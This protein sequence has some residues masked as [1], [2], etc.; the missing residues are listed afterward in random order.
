M[1]CVKGVSYSE[2]RCT[3]FI[4]TIGSAPRSAT[5]NDETTASKFGKTLSTG[6]WGGCSNGVPPVAAAALARQSRRA[7]NGFRQTPRRRAYK[8]S[9]LRGMQL[10]ALNAFAA[11]KTV[12]VWGVEAYKF[13]FVFVVFV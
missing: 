8:V 7:Y 4:S 5:E 9:L 11:Y 6:D 13:S 3:A 10:S 1:S 12:W 2:E